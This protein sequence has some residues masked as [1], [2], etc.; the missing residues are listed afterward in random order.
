[1]QQPGLG[2]SNHFMALHAEAVLTQ[3]VLKPE[4]ILKLG[5]VSHIRSNSIDFLLSN[6]KH[7][8]TT[9]L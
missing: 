3:Q 9:A 6:L 5:C 2:F 8:H 4:P 1:M 7:T